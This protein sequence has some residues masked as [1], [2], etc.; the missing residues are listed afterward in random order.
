MLAMSGLSEIKAGRKL[1]SGEKR[2]VLIIKP[3]GCEYKYDG[4]WAGREIRNAMKF[5]I[6]SY[7]MNKHK[8]AKTSILP[9]CKKKEKV[10]GD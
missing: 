5:L 2:V 8:M 3:D 10:N 6:R 7:R 1:S 9:Q 4:K